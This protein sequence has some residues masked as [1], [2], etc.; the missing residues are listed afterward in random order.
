MATKKVYIILEGGGFNGGEIYS[1]KR[2]AIRAFLDICGL[3]GSTKEWIKD[4]DKEKYISCDLST[5]TWSI[6]E[7]NLL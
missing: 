7:T 2:K 4:F 6:Q 3:Q 5:V 1:S